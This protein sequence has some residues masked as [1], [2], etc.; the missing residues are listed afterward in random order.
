M[1]IVDDLIE[2]LV[3]R[4]AIDLNGTFSIALIDGGLRLKGTLVSAVRD[5]KRK[6]QVLK[7]DVPIDLQISVGEIVIPLPQLE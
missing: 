4:N 3:E 6:K 5:E 2:N 7:V 1:S